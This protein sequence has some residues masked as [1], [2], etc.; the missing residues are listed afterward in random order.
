MKKQ[1]RK[2]VYLSPYVDEPL[3]SKVIKKFRTWTKK[4][5]RV[6]RISD[7]YV[8]CI[9]VM[10]ILRTFTYLYLVMVQG[11]EIKAFVIAVWVTNEYKFVQ[12]TVGQIIIA[13]SCGEWVIAVDTRPISLS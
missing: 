6:F 4:F 2:N 10:D 8:L 13:A 7:S 12:L 3:N 1:N 11:Q 9:Y 5:L